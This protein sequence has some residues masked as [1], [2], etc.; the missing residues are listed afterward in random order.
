MAQAWRLV[1]QAQSF[2]CN[3]QKAGTQT[4]RGTNHLQDD[5]EIALT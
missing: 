1:Y 5:G 4:H 2:T 3:P